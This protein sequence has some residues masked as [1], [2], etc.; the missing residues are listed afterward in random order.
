M[1]RKE[2]AYT[3]HHFATSTFPIMNDKLE[4]FA[5]DP[6]ERKPAQG[7]L[8]IESL[9]FPQNGELGNPFTKLSRK[10]LA[11]THFRATFHA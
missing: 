8:K 1:E 11:R 5:F 2:T 7:Q 4:E 10:P 6:G 9:R 3:D